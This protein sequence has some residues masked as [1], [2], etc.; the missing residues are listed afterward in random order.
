[1]GGM[2]LIAIVIALAVFAALI[3]SIELL[4]RI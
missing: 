3:A 2:D 4:D 1:V